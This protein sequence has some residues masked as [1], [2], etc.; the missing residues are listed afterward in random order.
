ML[1]CCHKVVFNLTTQLYNNDPINKV[2]LLGSIL[3]SNIAAQLLYRPMSWD[4]QFTPDQS[5]ESPK[6]ADRRIDNWQDSVYAAALRK[7]YRL[8]MIS[9]PNTYRP[10]S[11]QPKRDPFGRVRTVGSTMGTWMWNYPDPDVHQDLQDYQIAIEHYVRDHP[12]TNESF[13]PEL[14]LIRAKLPAE[15]RSNNAEYMPQTDVPLFPTP[16]PSLTP[17]ARAYFFSPH[18]EERKLATELSSSQTQQ[19]Q[20]CEQTALWSKERIKEILSYMA[21]DLVCFP[22]PD[23]ETIQEDN[24]ATAKKARATNP[25]EIPQLPSDEEFNAPPTPEQERSSTIPSELSPTTDTVMDDNIITASQ[26]ITSSTTAVTSTEPVSARPSVSKATST[27]SSSA[28]P[29]QTE[30]EQYLENVLTP[31]VGPES[32]GPPQI[33]SPPCGAI[34][35]KP[36]KLYKE[37]ERRP[38]LGPLFVHNVIIDQGPARGPFSNRLTKEQQEQR[39]NYIRSSPIWNL[40]VLDIDFLQVRHHWYNHLFGILRRQQ[41]ENVIDHALRRYLQV[42]QA[43]RALKA[44]HE[45]SGI[46]NKREYESRIGTRLPPMRLVIAP[47]QQPIVIRPRPVQ[48]RLPQPSR[49]DQTPILPYYIQ[50]TASPVQ[51]SPSHRA[52]SYELPESQER[53]TIQASLLYRPMSWDIQF[54]P[55][56][57]VESPKVADRRI[58]NW[59]DSVYAAAL[60]KRYRLAMISRPNTYRPSSAQPKRDPFGRVRTVGSTMGTWMW[61]YPDPDVHQDLQDYQIAIEHYVRDHPETNESFTP[62]LVLIRAKLP[63]ERR[64]NNAE[65]MP[66]TDV[67][68]FPTPIPSLTPEARAYFFS[69][70]YEER[71]LATELSSS[72]TQQRQPC[73]QT[74]LWSKERIKEILSYMADDLVCFPIPDKET[75]QE[76]NI[77]TA[78]KARAT[79]PAEIPQLPSDEEFNAPPTPE[80]ER[81][82]TIPSELSPTTDTV[83]DDNIIT[84]SQTITSSTTAVT[85]TEPVS[86]RPSVSKA[87]STESSSAQ[88]SQTETEQYLENVLTP[89][90][91]PE[92]V[93]PPQINSPPCGAICLKP[94]KLYKETERR[95][96]LGPLFV[97]N[98]IIDQGPARG[99]FSNRLTKE[100][101]EQRQ[102]YIRSSPIWNLYVLDIDFLQV[103]HHWYNH[104]FGILR[105]QQWENVIDHALRRYL[106]V[107]QANRAL[108]AMH[109]VSGI[110]NKREYES[111]IGTR[112]PPMRLVIAPVQQPI[113][114]RPRPVQIRLPQPSR[115][116]Q[117]PILPY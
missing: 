20:P 11:A 93:G 38:T 104:L 47:V 5:V 1:N 25:A 66:Q 86:A 23:K 50:R 71:K 51:S 100:Q 4:I 90:V 60:R 24:I 81:S 10:S 17:E 78:K 76:D 92:S 7:R 3:A 109:E 102:N 12:E 107:A 41:W 56:Q 45:V 94:L 69:P 8:A 85:S 9:R 80:Q 84:A 98:V 59:Q 79:N 6:V 73:E 82:S 36:L 110:I 96:T 2:T 40:Y 74:A 116:D 113:V 58:D 19:R 65:Y 75:I 72:Q 108:K 18:Y 70:H 33:N 42:A 29:S 22:I 34:C 101:Q 54:T 53:Q 30:T 27:E 99:P 63:A 97:H 111:R 52:L 68:L 55:D 105:R 106:Q 103:R 46:I 21:D 35:L 89:A 95:P 64:S 57:S 44:M 87:T 88:P 14:V 91:G 62:E 28:Q 32:V 31:A 39:Q 61:N 26:T 13:T 43:N 112:L 77:A 49:V 83:M 16:I 37:T 15:R 115:V 67:P 114:I 48:I 117:T